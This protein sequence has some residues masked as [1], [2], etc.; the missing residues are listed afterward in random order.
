MDRH[1]TRLTRRELLRLA[2]LGAGAVLV[3]GCRRATSPDPTATAVPSSVGPSPTVTGSA[4]SSATVTTQSRAYLPWVSRDEIVPRTASPTA[5]VVAAAETTATAEA[6]ATPAPTAEPTATPV[7]VATPFPPGPPSKLGIFLG[8]QHPALEQLLKTGNLPFVKT[9]EYDPNLVEFIKRISPDTLVVARYTPLGQF[10]LAAIDP[11]AKAREFV[12]LLL[13]IATEPKRRAHIDAWEAY[14]EPV[15]KS[16][17]EMKRLSDFEAER[18]R[19]L[20]AEGIRSCIGNFAA[21]TPELDLWPDFFPALREVQTHN[22]FLGLHEYSAPTM[23]FGTEG[24]T[25]WFTLRYRKLYRDYLEA[26]GL[27]VPLLITET[28]IDGGIEPRPGPPGLGWQDFTDYWKAEGEVRTTAAGFYME[29]LAWYDSELQKDAYVQGASI[30]ALAGPVGWGTFEIVG[31]MIPL[32][33]QYLTVHP[34]R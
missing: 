19:L 4:S 11:I 18:T 28:G 30:F 16:A 32:L 15:A 17:D 7:P 23:W 13:P 2:L 21:G 5:E 25:G 22:G 14:N 8:Y 34:Q 27:V 29:Q 10:D 12:D 24:E 26:A 33:A 1:P 31:D 20:A 6:T 9:L 3:D